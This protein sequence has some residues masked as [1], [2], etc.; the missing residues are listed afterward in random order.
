MSLI[1]PLLSLP[2]RVRK[3]RSYNA[4]KLPAAGSIAPVVT[5]SENAS[6]EASSQIGSQISRQPQAHE[7]HFAL[8]DAQNNAFKLS[9]PVC[10]I[11]GKGVLYGAWIVYSGY[12]RASSWMKISANLIIDGI[13]L[14]DQ[15]W[16]YD[17]K[18]LDQGITGLTPTDDFGIALK[19]PLLGT[20]K[21]IPFTYGTTPTQRVFIKEYVPLLKPLRF[22]QS[23]EINL[24]HK[25]SEAGDTTKDNVTARLC[26]AIY[27]DA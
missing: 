8:L 23:L 14:I 2:G 9:E 1:A 19:I 25:E 13:E 22:D 11:T 12:L 18:V 17:T 16:E 21:S 26:A 15:T 10:N 24:V 6:W 7:T 4:V 27:E 5:E 3:L 20:L